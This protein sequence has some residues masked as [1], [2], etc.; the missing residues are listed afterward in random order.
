MAQPVPSASDALATNAITIGVPREVS[1]SEHR[2]GLVPE[3]VN[4]LKASNLH[5]VIESGAGE[6]SSISDD[7]FAAAGAEIVATADAVYDRA[8]VIVQVQAPD[9]GAN[10]GVAMRAGTILIA[11]IESIDWAR[12]IRGTASMLKLVTL[13]WDSALTRSWFTSGAR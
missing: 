4:R 9:L 10:N 8:N 2:V 3:A 12:V 1:S 6:G 5:V 7:E 13:A 11:E